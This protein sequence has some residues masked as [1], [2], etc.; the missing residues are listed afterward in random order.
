MALVSVLFSG[1]DNEA[2]KEYIN[3]RHTHLVP[4]DQKRVS[5]IEKLNKVVDDNQSIPFN[6]EFLKKEVIPES[7]NLWLKLNDLDLKTK[8]VS[9]LNEKFVKVIVGYVKLYEYEVLCF[10][11][12]A[13]PELNLKVTEA[14]ADVEQELNRFIRKKRRLDKQFGLVEK[15]D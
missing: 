3:Y 5:L 15:E 8:D 11:P 10:E 13:D 14:M 6:Q 12:G 9:E 2:K 4:A 7:S 1:C